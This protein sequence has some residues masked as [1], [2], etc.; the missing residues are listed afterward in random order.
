MNDKA[1]NNAESKKILQENPQLAAA[2]ESMKRELLIVLINRLG[3]KIELPVQEI[4]GAGKYVML[5]ELSAKTKV[6][7]FAVIEKEKI[8]ND[9]QV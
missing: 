2:I 9:H 8:L 6:F 1:F 5:M 4:D 7:T 3:G